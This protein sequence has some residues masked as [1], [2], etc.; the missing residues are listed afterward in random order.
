MSPQ[1]VNDE[2]VDA[3][4]KMSAQGDIALK[5]AAETE[6]PAPQID[7]SEDSRVTIDAPAEFQ[8]KKLFI[9][10]ISWRSDEG[11]ESIMFF[12]PRGWRSS[13]VACPLQAQLFE[14]NYKLSLVSFSSLDPQ[15]LRAVRPAPQRG[16]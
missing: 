10:G 8:G 16:K 7:P 15:S 5:V 6:P 3:A 9:G 12:F 14:Q 4:A 13:A 2:E 1:P 11:K